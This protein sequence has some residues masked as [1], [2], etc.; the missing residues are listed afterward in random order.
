MPRLTDRALA[1]MA[2]NNKTIT[3]AKHIETPPIPKDKVNF[4]IG[5]SSPMANFN[6]GTGKEYSL[7][8]KLIKEQED[9]LNEY[10]EKEISKKEEEKKSSAPQKP[11]KSPPK[12]A[13]NKG[14]IAGGIDTF[15][16][17]NNDQIVLLTTISETLK[18]IDEKTAQNNAFLAAFLKAVQNGEIKTNSETFTNMITALQGTSNTNAKI[19]DNTSETLVNTMIG[20]VR[21]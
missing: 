19:N 13:T 11:V 7:T 16:T 6:I 4:G 15:N 14:G 3:L 9:K 2:S 5:T 8:D 1:D 17:S 18:A 20:L 12:T 21:Q 10:V